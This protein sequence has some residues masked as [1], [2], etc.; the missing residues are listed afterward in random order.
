MGFAMGLR[1]LFLD[2][3]SMM[4]QL[5][6]HIGAF[7]LRQCPST[8]P[9]EIY[10]KRNRVFETNII[11]LSAEIKEGESAPASR[12]IFLIFKC[13]QPEIA[14]L[15]FLLLV[16]IMSRC[17]IPFIIEA[18]MQR[19]EQSWILGLL[20][21]ALVFG[22]ILRHNNWRYGGYINVRIRTMLAKTLYKKLMRVGTP[23]LKS[24]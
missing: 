21:F 2:V 16:E 24:L 1:I 4:R 3:L 11:E 23:L 18:L 7:T 10:E 8:N 19:P 14:F 12:A 9:D 13:F 17:S 22:L 5:A 20:I 6:T 15:V